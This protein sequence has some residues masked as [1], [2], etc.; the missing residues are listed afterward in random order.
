[1][2]I[3]SHYSSKKD[4]VFV[5]CITG[6]YK[7]KDEL[8]RLRALPRV[9]KG[10]EIRFVDGPQAYSRHYVEPHDGLTQTQH[11]HLEEYGPGASPRK[12]G[13]W[14]GARSTY[15][16]ARAT[17]STTGSGTTGRRGTLRWSTTTACTST[18]T[19]IPPSRRARWC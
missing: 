4:R 14:R 6:H 17:R 5:R 19:P 8:A 2:G 16:T 15:S 18:S 9:R 11:I 12:P 1:M 7:L 3:E 10:S 13:T